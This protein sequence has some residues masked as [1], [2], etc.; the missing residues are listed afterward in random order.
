MTIYLSIGFFIF[1][2]WVLLYVF[3]PSDPDDGRQTI[4]D[5]LIT[6]GLAIVLALCWPLLLIG[7]GFHL[8]RG[9]AE[10]DKI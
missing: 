10:S 8:W 3:S 5:V 7:L 4:N 9:R 2:S 1:V 6:I